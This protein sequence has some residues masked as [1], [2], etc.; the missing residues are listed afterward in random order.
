MYPVITVLLSAL[1]LRERTTRRS[2]IGIALALPAV[3]LLSYVP[4]GNQAARGVGWLLLAILVTAAWGLQAYGMKFAGRTMRAESIYAYMTATALILI[5]AAVGMTD[6][7]RPINWG[8][9]GPYLAALVQLLNSIGALTIVYALRHGKA[10]VVVPMT[11]L[12][13]MLTVVI[14]LV[15]YQVIP[16]PLVL[17][18]LILAAIAI[19]LMA[20]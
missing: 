3:V 9:K 8:L 14:S 11:A 7:A 16:Q 17:C 2:C 10:I 1:L 4:P 20:E 18:G 6:F 15:L 19:F 12:A 5:P 13:P